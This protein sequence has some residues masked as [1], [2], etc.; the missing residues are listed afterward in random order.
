VHLAEDVLQDAMLNAYRAIAAG[1]MPENLEAWLF[2]LVRNC[3]VNTRRA[4]RAT[5]PLEDHH[6]LAVEHSTS[7]LLEQHE[8][9][10]WLTGAIGG[11]PVRQREALLGHVFE[12]RSHAEIATRQGTTVAAVKTLIHRARRGL[13]GSVSSPWHSVSLPILAG[14]RR[15]STSFTR[16]SLAGKAGACWQRRGSR[17]C[18]AWLDGMGLRLHGGG[19]VRG[20]KSLD[21]ETESPVAGGERK[22]QQ[23]GIECR[24]TMALNHPKCGVFSRLRGVLEPRRYTMLLCAA[25]L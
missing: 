8:W 18:R 20:N 17:C 6:E 14:A 16:R 10:D 7:A 4:T 3:V 15:L 5:V 12:G 2:T 24:A 9:M 25:R 13:A 11:L 22:E 21:R 1:A 23:N 19:V